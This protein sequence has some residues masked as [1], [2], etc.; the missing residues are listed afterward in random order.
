MEWGKKG[1]PF[2]LFP[3]PPW[4]MGEKKEEIKLRK[5]DARGD[6]K[7]GAQ[8]RQEGMSITLVSTNQV[9]TCWENKSC[10]FVTTGIAPLCPL[11]THLRCPRG[12]NGSAQCI[13]KAQ[14]C[15]FQNDCWDGFDEKNCGNYTRCN[16]E[17]PNLCGWIQAKND[18]MEWTR[19][20]GPTPSFY[21]GTLTKPTTKLWLFEIIGKSYTFL[22]EFK[23]GLDDFE[24]KKMSV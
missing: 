10:E 13:S 4:G 21:T 19:Q 1:K 3:P 11:R 7:G 12:K 20:Q 6:K 8:T 5:E 14:L 9:T 15:D 22:F 2:N 18:E 16:F 17:D 24:L 23:S